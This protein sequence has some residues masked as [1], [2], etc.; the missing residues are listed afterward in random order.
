[1]KNKL[2]PSQTKL[3]SEL[4]DREVVYVF[5]LFDRY[6]YGTSKEDTACRLYLTL[7]ARSLLKRGLC[8][9]SYYDVVPSYDNCI[10]V[11]ELI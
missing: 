10:G 5:R 2:T 11:L 3:L 6:T 8:R 1:M 7:T 9:H 4:K